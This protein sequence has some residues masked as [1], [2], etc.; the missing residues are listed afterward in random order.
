MYIEPS[1]RHYYV[2]IDTFYIF[3]STYLTAAHDDWS[4]HLRHQ[5]H[6]VDGGVGAAY[7]IAAYE[8]NFSLWI[9]HTHKCQ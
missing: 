7:D 1:Q 2:Q 6:I 9:T 4:A 3:P 5:P 8:T